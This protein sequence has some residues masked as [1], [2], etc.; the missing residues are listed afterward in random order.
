M[1]VEFYGPKGTP[2]ENHS[3]R[4]KF[5]FVTGYPFKPAEGFF[6]GMAPNHPFYAFDNDDEGRYKRTT[7]LANTN[8][9]ITYGKNIPQLYIPDYVELIKESL[10]EEGYKMMESYMQTQ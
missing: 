10:T 8:Y 3:Y 9:G 4:V 5:V 1:T 6:M 2:Y 7:N